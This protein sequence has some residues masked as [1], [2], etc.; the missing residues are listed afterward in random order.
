MTTLAILTTR[1]RV[2]ASHRRRMSRHRRGWIGCSWCSEDEDALLMAELARVKK[3]KE[4]AKQK[5][6]RMGVSSE[7]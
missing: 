3:E 1:T 7:G 4:L 2:R 5:E 6:V